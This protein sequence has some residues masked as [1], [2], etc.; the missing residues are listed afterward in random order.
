MRRAIVHMTVTSSVR[1]KRK[2]GC[3]ADV[4]SGG[5]RRQTFQRL[6]SIEIYLRILK[7]RRERSASAVRERIRP[8]LAIVRDVRMAMDCIACA[9]I[10]TGCRNLLI[11]CS[12]GRCNHS[13]VM[14]VDC[15]P[16]KVR[17]GPCVLR[18]CALRAVWSGRTCGPIGHR[19]RTG[20]RRR[21]PRV[22][23]QSSAWL[24]A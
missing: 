11:Y 22:L 6:R 5:H 17:C 4:G 19:T 23:S 7:D 1:F 21:I 24:C 2:I 20:G 16:M 9:R 3:R 12:S 18:W 14:N 13:A 10:P 15:C 8:R